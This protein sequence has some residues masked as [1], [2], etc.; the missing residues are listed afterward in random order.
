MGS[1]YIVSSIL[2]EP[3]LCSSN[4]QH[5]VLL[6][7]VL[8]DMMSLVSKKSQLCLVHLENYSSSKAQLSSMPSS[9]LAMCVPPSPPPE[10]HKTE[11]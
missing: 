11:S 4:P 9:L 6:L 10:A 7:G 1:F 2:W 8:L 3:S 5:I